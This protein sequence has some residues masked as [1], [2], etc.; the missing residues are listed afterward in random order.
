V[1]PLVAVGPTAGTGA[2][3]KPRRPAPRRRLRVP[4]PTGPL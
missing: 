4:T 3:G 2:A 1:C